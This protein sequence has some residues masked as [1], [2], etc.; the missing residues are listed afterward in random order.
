MDRRFVLGIL[1]LGACKAELADAP[2]DGGTS[3]QIDGNGFVPTDATSDGPT[4]LGAW[5]T[6]M[7]IPG[8]DSALGEDDPALTS[9]KLELIFKRSDTNDS[10]L[11]LMTRA[12]ATSAWGPVTP[13][14]VLN[15]GGNEE[16]P[17]L[18]P[19]DLTLYFA[20]DGEI[21]RSTRAAVGG[22]WGAA[23]TVPIFNTANVTEKW[24]VVCST[25]YAMVSRAVTNRGQDLFEGTLAAGANTAVT[26]L[27]STSN[28]Q[29]TFITSDCLRI[30]FQS[31]RTDGQFDIYTATRLNATAAWSNPTILPDFNTTTFDEE[32]AWISAD[33][34]TFVFASNASGNKDLYISTR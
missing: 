15:S 33:Q 10:N 23:T 5:G 21:Y 32:D 3:A 2:S 19:D 9:N 13:L 16:S 17:R 4:A 6:P 27:N 26:Q 28:E 8:G 30:Y 24:A 29:G 20:R 31:N 14:T 1:L 34:R 12:T 25:G 11:Y 7:K 22:A 18:S